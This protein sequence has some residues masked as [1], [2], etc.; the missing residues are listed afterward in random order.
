MTSI[1]AELGRLTKLTVLSLR[2]NQLTSV[3]VELGE[4][5]AMRRLYLEGRVTTYP[6][7][8]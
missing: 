2:H 7:S 4:L 8:I 3:P 6:I 5:K 1:P